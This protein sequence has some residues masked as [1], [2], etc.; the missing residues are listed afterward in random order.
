MAND[1]LSLLG[2]LSAPAGRDKT[3]RLLHHLAHFYSWYLV[4]SNGSP[5]ST[6]ACTLAQ[7][8]TAISLK[9]LRFGSFVFPLKA[10]VDTASNAKGMAP[11]LR[12]ATIGKHLGI[13]GYLAL[14]MA[15]LLDLADIRKWDKAATTQREAFR[16]WA[17]SVLFSIVEQLYTLRRLSLI[18]IDKGE[19][20][21]AV[22]VKRISRQRS[23]AKRQLV[24]DLCDIIVSNAAMGSITLNGGLVGLLGAFSCALNIYGQWKEV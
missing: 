6:A 10:A 24:C 14:D 8:H 19:G 12:Y 18:K 15:T 4:R 9:V 11:I 3:V 5:S 17:I 20:E 1:T 23:I 7:K 22:E 16:F 21:G 13:A 2:C